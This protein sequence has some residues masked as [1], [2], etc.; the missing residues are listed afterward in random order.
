MNLFIYISIY[1]IK[2]YI[3]YN[4]PFIQT[5]FNNV[6][7]IYLKL[8]LISLIIFGA[9]SPLPYLLNAFYVAFL[10][11]IAAKAGPYWRSHRAHVITEP[12]NISPIPP[13]RFF[14]PLAFILKE[15]SLVK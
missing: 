6:S 1:P 15:M 4:Y 12:D 5:L 14:P 3:N 11:I 10:I 7:S 8:L 9:V 2:F 13:Q